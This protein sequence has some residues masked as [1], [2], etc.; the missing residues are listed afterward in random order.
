M[1]SE[2]FADFEGGP[3]RGLG[4]WQLVLLKEGRLLFSLTDYF[5]YINLLLNNFKTIEYIALL[6]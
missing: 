6:I 2:V 4:W 3:I 1:F 5:T